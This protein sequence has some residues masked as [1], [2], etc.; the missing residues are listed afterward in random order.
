MK[1]NRKQELRDEMEIS[2]E[3]HMREHKV[4]NE[5]YKEGAEETEKR[6]SGLLG[7]F[8]RKGEKDYHWDGKKIVK[9]NLIF[10]RKDLEEFRNKIKQK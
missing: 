4:W 1:K 5:G 6:I 7:K 10:E 3:E 2:Y 9:D 8:E